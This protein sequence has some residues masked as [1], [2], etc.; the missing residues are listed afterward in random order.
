M[1]Y[2]LDSDI[3]IY[4]INNR[5]ADVRVIFEGRAAG[6][7]AISVVS[8]FELKAGA[9]KSVQSAQSLSLIERFT[10]PMTP[11]DFDA[12]DADAASR[13]R[14]GL[15]R[16]GQPIGPYDILIAAQALNREL[17]LVTNNER[18]FR[19]VPGLKIEN[20]AARSKA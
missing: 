18:E 13:L 3:C 14:A 12:A 2:L 6:D 17:T 19:R 7:S 15:E 9:H 5:P 1:K 8:L 11:L 10:S 20:W 16:K 4:I